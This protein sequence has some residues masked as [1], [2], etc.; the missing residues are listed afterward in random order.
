M[1]VRVFQNL[2]GSQKPQSMGDKYCDE[3]L[4]ML[5]SAREP[6]ENSSVYHNKFLVLRVG[7]AAGTR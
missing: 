2:V 5:E 7:G 4:M 1:K 6:Q 3:T